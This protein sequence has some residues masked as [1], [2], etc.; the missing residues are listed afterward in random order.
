MLQ[1]SK[2]TSRF[3]KKHVERGRK[4]GTAMQKDKSIGKN[5]ICTLIQAHP[6][7][8]KPVVKVQ[9]KKSVRE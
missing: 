9:P 2:R 8:E 1:P 7:A 4:F 3:R 5:V 6:L